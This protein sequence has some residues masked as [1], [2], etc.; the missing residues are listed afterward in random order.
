MTEKKARRPRLFLRGRKTRKMIA[1]TAAEL[2]LELG[3][4]KTTL[5]IICERANVGYRTIYAHFKNKDH[6]LTSIT[7]SI[8]APFYDILD[9][10]FEPETKEQ[11]RDLF[12]DLASTLIDI[13]KDKQQLLKIYRTEAS[14]SDLVGEHYNS[15][16]DELHQYLVSALTHSHKQGWLRE[17]DL[18]AGAKL[19]CLMLE[20]LFWE[21][22]NSKNKQSKL[23]AD[24][25][26][27]TF[28]HGFYI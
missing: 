19:L 7:D 26:A 2:F 9:E 8:F 10:P 18:D 27:D 12:F 15:V 17:C 25:A 4:F 1:N 21:S 11:A 13:T 14:Q 20:G 24:T 23:L 28:M 6:I 16:M 22:V 3:Y 5:V